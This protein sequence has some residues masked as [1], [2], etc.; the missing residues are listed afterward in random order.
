[1]DINSNQITIKIKA[2]HVPQSHIR[3]F[4]HQIWIDDAAHDS[5]YVM[6][7]HV[8]TIRTGDDAELIVPYHPSNSLPKIFTANNDQSSINI[9]VDIKST[10]CNIF[11]SVAGENNQNLLS[12]QKELVV[13]HWRLSHIGFQWLQMMMM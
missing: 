9:T 1:M 5:C 13:W 8:S 11:S 3:L 10:K 12:V 4:S 6:H 7:K 2:L